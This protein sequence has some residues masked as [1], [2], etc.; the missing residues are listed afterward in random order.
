MPDYMHRFGL[1]GSSFEVK[2][3]QYR[4]LN[5]IEVQRLIR[6]KSIEGANLKG[7]MGNIED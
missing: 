1:F 5:F 6:L 3:I 7:K 4:S 2:C